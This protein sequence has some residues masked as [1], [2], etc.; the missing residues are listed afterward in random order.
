MHTDFIFAI[1]A[2]EFGL[3]GIAILITLF[4]IVVWRGFAIARRAELDG[5]RFSAYVCYGLSGWLGLQ[6]LIH[7][8]VNMGLLPPKGLTFP[9]PRYGGSLL[10]TVFALL[11]LILP[12]GYENPAAAFGVPSGEACTSRASQARGP[13]VRTR[14]ELG[15]R[16]DGGTG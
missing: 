10:L 5:R 13:A 4:G 6:A 9:L 14:P 11:G 7:M 12:V 3:L 15:S 1:L 16:S 2:E 8:A